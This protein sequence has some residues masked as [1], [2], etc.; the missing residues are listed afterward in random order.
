MALAF[1]YSSPNGIPVVPEAVFQDQAP[2]VDV[3]TA[4]QLLSRGEAVLVDARPP[5]LFQQK[6]IA[7]AVNIPAALFDVIYPMKLGRDAQ[8]RADGA[9]LR[10]HHQQALR[11]RCGPAPAAAP[12]PGRRSWKAG[13]AAW[14]EKGFAVAP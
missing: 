13:L 8:T 2:R 4:H 14:E 9:G 7:E 1:N 6:H 10:P 12:R 3:L 5:E 11:R